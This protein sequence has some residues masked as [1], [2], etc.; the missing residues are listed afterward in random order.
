M[1][2]A[3][4]AKKKIAKLDA[5][6]LFKF[7]KAEKVQQSQLFDAYGEAQ[8]IRED[9]DILDKLQEENQAEGQ[10]LILELE[11]LLEEVES[12]ELSESTLKSIDE[13]FDEY[14]NS[15]KDLSPS[16]NYDIR[17]TKEVV[18][19]N[20]WEY[21]FDRVTE[22]AEEIGIDDDEDPFLSLLGEKEYKKLEDQFKRSSVSPE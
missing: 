13:Y 17:K 4:M 16:V 2:E 18:T 12:Q 19:N 7:G 21:Y 22:H 9:L 14:L 20:K 3:Q 10:N 11:N 15:V 5:D 6:T 1:R 8:E